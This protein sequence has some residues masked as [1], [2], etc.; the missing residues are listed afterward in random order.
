MDPEGD[1][2]DSPKRASPSIAPAIDTPH[3][4]EWLLHAIVENIPNM[5]FVKDAEQLA[6]ALFNR[7]GEQLLGLPREA[8]IG[9]TDFDLFPAADAEFFQKK[10]RETLAGKLLVDIEEEPIQTQRGVRWLHT[11]K[12]PILDTNGQP[13]FL[14]GISEDITDRKLA[15]SA[16]REAKTQA[17][18]ASAE[19]E[20]FSYS[21]AHDLRA[22]LRAI[23]GYS[24]ALLDDHADSLDDE[25]RRLLDNVRRAAQRMASLIDDL[26]TLSR[27][28]RIDLRREPTDIGALA[29]TCIDAVRRAAPHREV[30]VVIEDGLTALAD[31]RLVVVALDNLLANAWKFTSKQARARIEV[32]VAPPRAAGEARTF[33]V[34][35]DGAGFDMAYVGKLFTP[36][37]RL[38]GMSEYEGTGIGLATVQRI[39]RRHGGRAWAEGQVGAG[40]TVYFTLEPDATA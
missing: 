15:D 30:E 4:T 6:F 24:A 18:T 14:L 17:E 25:G 23:D 2:D 31:P 16:L 34:R 40:A 35:D 33:F 26:L 1:D 37:Q 5:L 9:R 22:P 32:G 11:K 13:R 27:A 36:F 7:A 3:A 29:R 38:H 12:V 28:T 39:M 21:V 10:D 20:A 8:L 19:L